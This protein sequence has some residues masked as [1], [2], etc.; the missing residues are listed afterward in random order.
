MRVKLLFLKKK[1]INN[2]QNF[3]HVSVMPNEVLKYLNAE[4]MNNGIIVDCTFGGVI[5][6]RCIF[7]KI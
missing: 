3:S 7:S 2:K 1:C 4:P 5:N 6:F